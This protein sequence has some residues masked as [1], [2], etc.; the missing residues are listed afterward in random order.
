MITPG[1]KTQALRG[2]VEQLRLGQN[3]PSDRDHG[4]GGENES[5]FKLVIDAH[6]GQCGLGLAAGKPRGTSP[7]Q[8]APFRSFVDIGRPQRVRLDARL[9]NQCEPA[10]RTGSEHEFWAADHLNR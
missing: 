9:I 2:F 3:A 7:R 10:R 4:I 6:H 5:A 1:Q 8:F